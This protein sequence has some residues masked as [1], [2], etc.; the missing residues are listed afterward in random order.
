MTDFIRLHIDGEIVGEKPM[1][2]MF[3][4]DST[5][6]GSGKI[7]LVSGGSDVASEQAY[8]Y[9]LKTLSTTLSIKDHFAKV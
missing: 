1:S 5:V 8:I 7:T 4:K 6:N 9:N 2:S 3:E